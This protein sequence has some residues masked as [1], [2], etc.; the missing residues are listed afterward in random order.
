MA[1]LKH[2]LDEI[3]VHHAYLTGTRGVGKTTLSRIV[4]LNAS[5]ARERMA[6]VASPVILRDAKTRAIC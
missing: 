3:V 6:M 1:A 2:A 4:W 5:I